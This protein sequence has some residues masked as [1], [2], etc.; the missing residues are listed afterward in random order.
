[1]LIVDI[2]WLIPVQYIM[3]SYYL[4]MLCCYYV[5]GWVS[6]VMLLICRVFLG[7]SF[8]VRIFP[9]KSFT[10]RS[11]CEL[12]FVKILTSIFTIWLEFLNINMFYVNKLELKSWKL[13]QIDNE[14]KCSEYWW[15]WPTKLTLLTLNLLAGLPVLEAQLN[16]RYITVFMRC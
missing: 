10:V 2:C 14:L 13:Y 9:E 5:C 3:S 6:L 4:F 8:T 7:K 1:M 11:I 12:V 15:Y 16:L